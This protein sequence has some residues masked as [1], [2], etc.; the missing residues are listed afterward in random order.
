[1]IYQYLHSIQEDDIDLLNELRSIF[2]L[3]LVLDAKEVCEVREQARPYLE[4][5][6]MC[7]SAC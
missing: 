6:D 5:L 7:M 3:L 2:K 4:D 1:M